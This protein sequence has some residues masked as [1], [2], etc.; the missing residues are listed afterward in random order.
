MLLNSE[1][2][3]VHRQVIT[4]MEELKR[5]KDERVVSQTCGEMVKHSKGLSV[6][7]FTCGVP[8]H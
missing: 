7:V 3:G 8:T 5:Q 2:S 1:A 6:E 4:M